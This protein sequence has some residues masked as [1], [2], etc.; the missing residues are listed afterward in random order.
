MGGGVGGA[1]H[2]PVDD[3]IVHQ[4]GAEVGHVADGFARLFQ[5]DTLVLAEFGVLL[6]E[7][8]AQFAGAR[9]DD[10]G[11]AKID[12]KFCCAGTDFGLFTEDC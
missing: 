4:H 7:P 6:G 8:L 3:V 9:V 5:G 11:G 2:H 1:R 10:R 12:T